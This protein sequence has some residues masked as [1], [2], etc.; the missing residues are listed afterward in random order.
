[1]AVAIKELRSNSSNRQNVVEENATKGV[2]PDWRFL[3]PEPPKRRRSSYRL[4]SA[5]CPFFYYFL[6]NTI[7]PVLF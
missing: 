6:T 4:L 5:V 3:E 7:F 2:Q 1:L